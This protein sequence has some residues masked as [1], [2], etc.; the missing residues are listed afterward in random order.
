M[1][2]KPAPPFTI[3]TPRSQL[4]RVVFVALLLTGAAGLIYRVGSEG[5]G[6]KLTDDLV[7]FV[8][9]TGLAQTVPPGPTFAVYAGKFYKA[10]PTQTETAASIV[11]TEEA[12]GEKEKQRF[13]QILLGQS[14][15]GI[16][17]VENELVVQTVPSRKNIPRH[18]GRIGV[19]APA[20]PF[21]GSFAMQA[22]QKTLVS[23]ETRKRQFLSSIQ[24]PAPLVYRYTL[25]N[26]VA[27]AAEPSD[28]NCPM[29]RLSHQTIAR[30]GV[31][32]VDDPS[33]YY[34]LVQN[35]TH[36]RIE[37]PRQSQLWRIARNG[38]S[39]V[40]AQG[41]TVN[42][43]VIAR[44]GFVFWEVPRPFPDKESDL[45]SLPDNA[46]AGTT[47][48]RCRNAPQTTVP[49]LVFAGHFYWLSYR[50]TRALSEENSFVSEDPNVGIVSTAFDGS[51]R[52]T[53]LPMKALKGEIVQCGLF[54]VDGKLYVRYFIY[55][56][57]HVSAKMAEDG[58]VANNASMDDVRGQYIVR[59]YPERSDD[60]VWGTPVSLPV[61]ASSGVVNG[62][63]L[64]FTMR[65][66]SGPTPFGIV[67]TVADLFSAT[68]TA[69]SQAGVYRVALPQ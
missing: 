13:R 49:N 6:E 67:N 42:T 50:S 5:D 36:Q 37:Y 55:Q 28:Q 35:K 30:D 68:S 59:L 26:P 33:G 41:L 38:A 39:R 20:L 24:E 47:P 58:F 57:E 69:R 25:N 34:D 14:I 60:L 10:Q 29:S 65:Q 62:N 22:P 9:N 40:V 15:V 44:D 61:E 12:V 45:F 21:V 31:Y 52:R 7:P 56:A 48:V 54:A 63:Y 23:G 43:Q 51:Q 17:F 19:A 64:Y 53:L 66:P 1:T 32:S 18:V 46:L 11:L 27:V 2:R 16:Q 8:S 4:P 3:T